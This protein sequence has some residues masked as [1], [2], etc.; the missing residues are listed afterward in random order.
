MT[1][2]QFS[3]LSLVNCCTRH[4]LSIRAGEPANFFPAPAPAPD[5]FFKRL[6]LL[7]F[8]PSGSGSGSWFFFKRLRLRLQGAKNTW[9]RLP[10]PAINYDYQRQ[11]TAYCRTGDSVTCLCL[12]MDIRSDLNIKKENVIAYFQPTYNL[13]KKKKK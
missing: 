10:S 11:L 3:H 1:L 4:T 9:L 12:E 7:I 5:F 6:R 2:V 13:T 8:F